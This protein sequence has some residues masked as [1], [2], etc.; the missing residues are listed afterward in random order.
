MPPHI[1]SA[2]SMTVCAFSVAV[3]L[4][5]AASRVTVWPW[6]RSHAARYVSKAAP[7]MAVAICASL[8]CVS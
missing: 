4:A 6:S 5:M 3:I 8:A 1:C 7:S 2:A